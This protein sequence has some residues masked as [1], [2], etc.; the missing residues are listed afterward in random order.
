MKKIILF[1]SLSFFTGCA[2]TGFF[3]RLGVAVIKIDKE[4]GAL[5][6][7]KG[8]SLKRGEACAYNILGLV[9]YGDSSIDKA[10]KDGNMKKIS[11][12]DYDIKN[13]FSFFGS[14]CTIAHGQ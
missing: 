3:T 13:F 4:A 5:N 12:V 11:Y 9:A 6:F 8:D 7:H 14:V 2:T 10:K 1:V